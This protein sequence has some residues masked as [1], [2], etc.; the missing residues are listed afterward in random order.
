MAGESPDKSEQRKS[1]GEATHERDPRFAV[2]RESAADEPDTTKDASSDRE[3]SQEAAVDHSTAVFTVRG[4]GEPQGLLGP[5]RRLWRAWRG[6]RR[7]W[8]SPSR[9]RSLR[10]G[11][12]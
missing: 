1:S 12:E 11:R 7:V 6:L 10:A 4:P 5:L 9:R 3:G 2:F 8:R